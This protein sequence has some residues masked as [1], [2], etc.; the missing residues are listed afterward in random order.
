MVK[1]ISRPAVISLFERK[2][3][4]FNKVQK[5]VVQDTFDEL[6]TQIESLSYVNSPAEWT[7]ISIDCPKTDGYYLTTSMYGGVYS[8]YWSTDHFDRTETVIAWMPLPV[9]YVEE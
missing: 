7:P 3:A 1:L 6:L 2:F 9:P 5:Q 8:D 4:S